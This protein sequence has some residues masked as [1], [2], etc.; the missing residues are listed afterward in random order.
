MAGTCLG[1][2]EMP[3]MWF[4]QPVVIPGEP[5]LKLEHRTFN[6]HVESG[7]HDW[8]RNMPW[9]APGT[10]PVLGSGCGVAG[11]NA[12]PIANGG[13]APAGYEQGI[14][15]LSLPANEPTVW[16]KGQVTEV[17]WAFFANHGGGYSWRLCKKSANI[18]EECFQQNVLHFHGEKSWIQYSDQIPNH[19]GAIK[20]PRFEIPRITV[21]EGTFPLGSEWARNPIPSCNYCDQSKCGTALPNVTELFQPHL[22]GFNDDSYWYGGA[23]WFEQEK[24]AQDCSGFSMMQC[25]PGMTQFEEPLPGLSGYLGNYLVDMNEPVATAMGVEGALYSIVDLVEVP[26][27]DEGEYLLSFRWDCEQ[28]PQIWQSCADILIVDGNIEV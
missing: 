25:P 17:A 6:V 14:D 5:T 9:R 20:L 15:G 19:A 2:P 24:C 22:G 1:I 4:S 7:P 26:Q 16:T 8:S 28:S 11:G 3:C 10:A 12:I 13:V 27:V 23:A 21:S 18:S